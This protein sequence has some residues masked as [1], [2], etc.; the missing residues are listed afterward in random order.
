MIDDNNYD[1]DIFW[2]FPAYLQAYGNKSEFRSKP[3]SAMRSGDWKL[4]YNYES[5][6]CELY[7]LTEDIGEGNNLA[8]IEVKRC[9]KMYKRMKAWLKEVDAPITFELNP[10]YVKQ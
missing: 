4:I 5:E 3:Y 2:H 10:Q 9:N 1:R 8:E 6:S 7:N